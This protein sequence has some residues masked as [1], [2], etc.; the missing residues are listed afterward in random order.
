[1]K[2]PKGIDPTQAREK[3]Q[4]GD[5]T[6]VCAYEEVEKCGKVLLDGAIPLARLRADLKNR[7]KDEELVFYCA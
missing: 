3:V 5:A 6:L 7:N 1:M 2:K 4:A